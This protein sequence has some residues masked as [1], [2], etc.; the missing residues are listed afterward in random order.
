MESAAPRTVLD[1]VRLSAERYPAEL[2][3][4]GTTPGATIT[5]AALQEQV[6]R[7]ANTLRSRG[8]RPSDPVLVSLPNGP[9]M[10][11]AI[12][13]TMSA[14]VCAPMNPAYTLGELERLAQDIG[15]VAVITTTASA[16]APAELAHKHGLEL[17]QFGELGEFREYGEFAETAIAPPDEPAP[18]LLLHT[19]GTT[20][21]PKQVPLSHANLVAAARNVVDSLNLTPADRCLN[22]MPLF[23]S[24]GLLGAAMSSLLAGAGIVCTPGMDPRRFLGWASEFGCNWYTAAP[25]I[26]QLV[27][28]APGDWQGFRF[29]RS[30]SAPLPPQIAA[31]L[32]TR[33]GAPMIEVY[34]MTEAYQIAANPLPPGE[35]RPGTVGK[36]TGTE[37]AVLDSAGVPQLTGGDGEVV[38][39]GPA[40]FRGYSSPVDANK[41]AF[42]Q[43][44]FR[45][46]DVGRISADGYLTIT[47]R[48]KEQINRGGEKI[49]P[50][51]VEEALLDHPG[52]TEV[53]AFAIPDAQLGEEIGVAIVPA[54]GAPIDLA[55]VRAF[56]TGRVAPF[57]VPKRVLVVD[58]IP[59]SDTG[60]P[61]RIAFAR[62]HAAE[63]ARDPATTTPMALATDASTMQRLAALW[64]EI[65]HL[66]QP[67]GP[68]DHFFDL[69]GTSL[70]VMELVIR[71]DD[72]FGLDL[73]V[74]DVLE[75]PTLAD[76]A[77]RLDQQAPSG[78]VPT[79]LLRRYRQGGGKTSI[80]LAPGQI[81]MA[82]GLNLI[83]DAIGSDVDVYLFDYPGHRPGQVPLKS[84]EE[85][86]YVLVAEMQ[87]AGIA[88][89]VAL[90][91]NSMGSWVAFEA[92]RR[93]GALG[94]PALFVG[95]G[96]MYSPYFNTKESPLRP[97]LTQ[98]LRN[99]LRRAVNQL[100]RRGIHQ[101]RDRPTALK[102]QQ[103]VSDASEIARRSYTPQPYDGDLLVVV[104]SERAPKFGATLG[105]ERHTTGSIT[106]L[107]V[108]GGHSEMHHEQ[109]GPI[110]A[111]LTEML[112]SHARSRPDHG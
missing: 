95:I 36:A 22:V 71:I 88:H 99:R 35:R 8:V 48:V 47:G 86:A 76:L 65:L 73:P 77:A 59:K 105:Y 81:G 69:G 82:V 68:T 102:R 110:G 70:A 93:L 42:I 55:T 43:G 15:V 27:L 78:G 84:V 5:Y 32:E 98:R 9:T 12:L 62:E 104:A 20:A 25:T 30:A 106:C 3:L 89:E 74:L 112:L 21:H 97:P 79:P 44:W 109:A 53:I 4:L 11:T 52:I 101:A 108:T 28:Q 103:A 111:A 92:A 58:Q 31:A 40:A 64:S 50:R 60:K 85:L 54:P 33:Y 66:E 61:Q 63:L 34:G 41:E 24:H 80:V 46:G 56:L 67:P 7:V 51:E 90:Y 45:T 100:R 87:R 18:A 2:A 26:H 57:K 6:Q 10:L 29:M 13:G 1:I 14:A 23:H 17:L 37:I 16:G 49:S 94:S 39:R 91:G 38:V 19:A 107:R 75:V 72:E 83:A 96:D